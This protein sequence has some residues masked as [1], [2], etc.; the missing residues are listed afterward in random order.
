MITQK[1]KIITYRRKLIVD[2][3]MRKFKWVIGEGNYFIIKVKNES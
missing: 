2:E 1:H 3:I